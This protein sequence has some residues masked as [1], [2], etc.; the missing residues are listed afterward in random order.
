MEVEV[1]V[2]VEAAV[3]ATEVAEDHM[4]HHQ[5]LSHIFRPHLTHHTLWTSL[6]AIC[7]HHLWEIG[8]KWK[9]F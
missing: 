7:Q 5:D 4:D 8:P 3:E 9:I 2:E 6:S 1:E